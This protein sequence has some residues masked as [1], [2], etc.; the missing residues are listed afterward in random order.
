MINA[1]LIN[2][3]SQVGAVSIEESGTAGF[4]Q[5]DEQLTLG[6]PDPLRRT[7][8]FQ[9]GRTDIGNQSVSRQSSFAKHGDLA[10]VVGSYLN[11]GL[12]V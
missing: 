2:Q 5:V 11:N 7:E 9:M 10:D 8:T 1:K 12:L 4:F 3:L 6:L